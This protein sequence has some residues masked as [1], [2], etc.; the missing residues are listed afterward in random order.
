MRISFSVKRLS[1]RVRNA[2][3]C[4]AKKAFVASI[5]TMEIRNYQPSKYATINMNESLYLFVASII[6]VSYTQNKSL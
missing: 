3:D 5:K 4:I 2:R 6:A 1:C